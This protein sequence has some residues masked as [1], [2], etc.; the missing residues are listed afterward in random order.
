MKYSVK[1][2]KELVIIEATKLRQ[3]ATILERKK[4]NFYNLKSYQKESCIYG[5]MTGDCYSKRACELINACTE[6]VYKDGGIS[7]GG[8]IWERVVLNGKPQLDKEGE[9][10]EK[11]YWWFSPIEVFINYNDRG[12]GILANNDILIDYIQGLTDTLEFL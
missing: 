11:K 6:R 1:K 5:Q 3:Q 9:R 4:L 10:L 2:L 7:L 8:R 12:D